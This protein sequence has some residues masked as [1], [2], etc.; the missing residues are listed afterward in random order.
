MSNKKKKGRVIGTVSF[1]FT[2]HDDGIWYSEIRPDIN[3]TVVREVY[4]MALIVAVLQDTCK[5]KMDMIYRLIA[6][7]QEIA[8]YHNQMVEEK[9][10][11]QT[12]LPLGELSNE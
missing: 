6:N 9:K 4:K 7:N 8:E 11:H 12:H 5:T 1:E 10:Q 3:T 2:E